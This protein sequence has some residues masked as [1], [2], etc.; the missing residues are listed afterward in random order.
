MNGSTATR[1]PILLCPNL[2][3]R[4]L[5]HPSPR[6]TFWLSRPV[7]N[8]TRRNSSTSETPRQ[9]SRPLQPNPPLSRQRTAAH[10]NLMN[11]KSV[12]EKC[13]PSPPLEDHVPRSGL[14]DW[15]N[16]LVAGLG[17]PLGRGEKAHC[18]S[19]AL[20]SWFGFRPSA[21]G[22][23]SILGRAHQSTNPPIHP[24]SPGGPSVGP[25]RRW[26]VLVAPGSQPPFPP[27]RRSRSE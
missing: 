3:F 11:S 8:G 21:F 2:P 25:G 20:G 12:S 7:K 23:G 1:L 18:S 14:H 9:C 13:S 22:F 27:E 17:K 5:F 26:K 24:S 16:H 15:G 19:L 10:P 6:P 4:R